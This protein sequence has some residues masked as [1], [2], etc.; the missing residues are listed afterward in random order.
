MLDAS[1]QNAW[2]LPQMR[3][4]IISQKTFKREVAMN[5]LKCRQSKPK[6]PGRKS[7]NAAGAQN[8]RYDQRSHMVIPIPNNKRR[9][10][11]AEGC[12]SIVKT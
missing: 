3:R 7:K 5:Y 9:R 1:L 12:T 4:E 8:A 6:I 2:L 10:C 11:M